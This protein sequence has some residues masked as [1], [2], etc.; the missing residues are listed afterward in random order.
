MA[1]DPSFI[2]ADEARCGLAGERRIAVII[3]QLMACV[4]RAD[5]DGNDAIFIVQ[6]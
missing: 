4:G 3:C 5:E 6:Y 1:S 2:I